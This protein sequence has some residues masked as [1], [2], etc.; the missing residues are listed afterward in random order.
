[1]DVRKAQRRLRRLSRIPFHLFGKASNHKKCEPHEVSSHLI[2]FPVRFNLSVPLHMLFVARLQLF[3][4]R[5]IL[6]YLFLFQYLPNSYLFFRDNRFPPHCKLNSVYAR[7]LT[8]LS[9]YKFAFSSIVTLFL[10][11]LSQ[12]SECR[13]L[14]WLE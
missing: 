12:I 6:I 4:F 13:F 10:S 1:M 9:R 2:V 8:Q 14:K 11:P 5:G 3:C 7:K